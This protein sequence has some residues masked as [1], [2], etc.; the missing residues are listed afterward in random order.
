MIWSEGHEKFA[1]V[2]DKY[3]THV[4]PD[5]LLAEDLQFRPVPRNVSGEKR[6]DENLLPFGRKKET[7]L[8]AAETFQYNF[9]QKNILAE[10]VNLG[11]N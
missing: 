6:K 11:R 8:E 2:S 9:G 4:D 5:A 7:A 10:M 1:L 3:S